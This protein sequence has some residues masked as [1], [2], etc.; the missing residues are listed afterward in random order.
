[1]TPGASGAASDRRTGFAQ[2]A[3]AYPDDPVDV[4]IGDF[5][6]EAN[7]TSLAARKVEGAQDGAFEATFVEAVTPALGNIAKHGIKAGFNAVVS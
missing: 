1:L 3:S 4:I 2:F 6:S 7:M 5:M